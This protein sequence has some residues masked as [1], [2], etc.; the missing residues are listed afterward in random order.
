MG[1]GHSPH[2]GR[3]SQSRP[4][5]D[6]LLVYVHPCCLLLLHARRHVAGALCP[7]CASVLRRRKRLRAAARR[8]RPRLP[9]LRDG[10]AQLAV[11]L[12][13]SK[14]LP[15]RLR[16]RR[17]RRWR[18]GPRPLPYLIVLAEKAVGNCG[19][20]A[21][22]AGEKQA[23]R[24]MSG[25]QNKQASNAAQ[26]A[27]AGWACSRPEPQRHAG[28]QQLAGTVCPPACPAC[29]RQQ[30]AAVP[31]QRSQRSKRSNKGSGTRRAA[32]TCGQLDA[33]LLVRGPHQR[34]RVDPPGQD[35]KLLQGR[36][37]RLRAALLTGR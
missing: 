24:W 34:L 25:W 36:R 1:G 4:E 19:D 35:V 10:H 37:L 11:L 18:C 16:R 32:P 9:L 8:I 15:R 7:C 21:V 14:V 31:A 27:H 23:T 33:V 17:R 13:D 3:P 20:R 6:L 5:S 29:G 12:L 28:L 2:S 22:G 30:T 26:L